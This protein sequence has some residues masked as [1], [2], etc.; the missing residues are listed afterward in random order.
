MG[1]GLY[2]YMECTGILSCRTAHLPMLWSWVPCV[3]MVHGTSNSVDFIV[4]LEVNQASSFHYASKLLYTQLPS[5][6]PLGFPFIGSNL[7][8]K[9]EFTG[10]QPPQARRIRGKEGM[11]RTWKLLQSV[12]F[13]KGWKNEMESSNAEP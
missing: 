1:T 2:I 3:V 7:N 10:Q 6:F 11:E 5:R 9:L 12:G 13:I 4:A 8:V